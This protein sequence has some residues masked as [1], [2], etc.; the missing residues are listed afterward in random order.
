M[1]GWV[2]CSEKHVAISTKVPPPPT[3][4]A[5]T[6]P[7]SIPTAVGPGAA[8]RGCLLRRLPKINTTIDNTTKCGRL[9]LD[10]RG[11]GGSLWLGSDWRFFFTGPFWLKIYVC[12]GMLDV[13]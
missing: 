4:H 6:P 2:G 1:G 3:R 8:A 5:T 9:L 13:V 10:Y 7:P 11:G 12:R